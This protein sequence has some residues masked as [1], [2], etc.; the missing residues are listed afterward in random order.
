MRKIINFQIVV[1]I[2]KTLTSDSLFFKF[3]MSAFS[4][5][6]GKSSKYFF[7]LAFQSICILS[8]RD[9]KKNKFMEIL[10]IPMGLFSTDK[11]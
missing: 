8:L 1:L 6:L 2:C 5:T 3:M 10:S 7:M 9:W 4:K 11:Y